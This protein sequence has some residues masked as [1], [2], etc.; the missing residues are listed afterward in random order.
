ME[1]GRGQYRSNDALACD[2]RLT[3]LAP[4]DNGKLEH[5][6]AQPKGKLPGR[7]DWGETN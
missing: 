1:S 7:H 6:D 5:E 4:F 3:D 2:T